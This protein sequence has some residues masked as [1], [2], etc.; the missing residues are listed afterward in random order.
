ME[1]AHPAAGGVTCGAGEV[2]GLIVTEQSVEVLRTVE[3]RESG[4][5]GG[6]MLGQS[7]HLIGGILWI[8]NPMRGMLEGRE[9]GGSHMHAVGLALSLP[10]LSQCRP[11]RVCP[12][13]YDWYEPL[14][15]LHT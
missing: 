8:Q 5:Q 14:A 9:E 10:G 13:R 4:S 12:C 7:P 2:T 6:G 3:V 1:A 15:L 11:V